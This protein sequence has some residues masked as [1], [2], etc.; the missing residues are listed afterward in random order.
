MRAQIFLISLGII[1]LK[2]NQKL[3]PPFDPNNAKSDFARLKNKKGLFIMYSKFCFPTV[4]MEKLAYIMQ[5]NASTRMKTIPQMSG[6]WIMDRYEAELRVLRLS[7]IQLTISRVCVGKQRQGAMTGIFL[8]LL[9]FCKE[10]SIEKIVIQSVLTLPMVKWC[11][12]HGFQA[13]SKLHYVEDSTGHKYYIPTDY[14]L[15]LDDSI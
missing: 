12:D 11:E 8:E 1:H 6:F 3:S 14:V 7:N 5:V 9:K 10:E 13:V 15:Y 2:E 4:L